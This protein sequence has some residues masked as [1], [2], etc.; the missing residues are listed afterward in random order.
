MLFL[1]LRNS[2]GFPLTTGKKCPNFSAWWSGS[3]P[4]AVLPTSHTVPACFHWACFIT[5]QFSPLSLVHVAFPTGLLFPT[6]FCPS[7]SC[8]PSMASSLNNYLYSRPFCT[9]VH[10]DLSLISSSANCFYGSNCFYGFHTLLCD[11]MCW[12]CLPWSWNFFLK[13]RTKWKQKVPSLCVFC[14]IYPEAEQ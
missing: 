10:S 11:V 1:Y 14:N 5:P 2:S 13:N 8:H 4:H 3:S 12:P 9:A 7:E 6:F